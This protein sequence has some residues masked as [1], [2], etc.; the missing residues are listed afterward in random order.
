MAHPYWP[1][2]DLRV[3][4]P[5]LELRAPSDEDA[6]AL[7]SMAAEGVHDPATTPFSIPWTD[8]PSPHLE[9]GALQ[10]IWRCRAEW[11]PEKWHLPLA[12]CLEGQPVGVQGVVGEE[13]AALRSVETGSWLGRRFQGRGLGREMRAAVL[14]LAF[15]GLGAE[16]ALSG[17]WHDNGPSIAVSRALGYEDNG[18]DVKLRRQQPDRQVRFVLTRARWE[19][20]A[21]TDSYPDIA[22]DQLEPCLDLFGLR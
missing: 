13:F 22:I 3:R 17:A 4:T 18:E 12:V 8:Q 16:R 2:F 6:V 15:A 9:Q 10:F 19:E 1:L 5:R 7:A 21:R 20:M 14:H 11:T